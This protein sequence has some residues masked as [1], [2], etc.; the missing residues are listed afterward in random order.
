MDGTHDEEVTLVPEVLQ[1]PTPPS[2]DSLVGADVTE[3]HSD[4]HSKRMDIDDEAP[5]IDMLSPMSTEAEKS[6]EGDIS[7]L[8]NTHIGS[9]SMGYEF[10]NIR[11][12]AFSGMSNK[13]PA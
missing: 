6:E 5:A 10:S 3:T 13:V 8:S 1:Q 7:A 4:S 2:S 11:V 9:P 12:C